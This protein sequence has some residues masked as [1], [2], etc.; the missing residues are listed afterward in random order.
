MSKFLSQS[1]FSVLSNV[2]K[3]CNDSIKLKICY[4]NY[5]PVHS[6]LKRQET[7]RKNNERA[8]VCSEE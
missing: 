4:E 7:V 8:V 5:L 1:L 3:M 6:Y 2:L